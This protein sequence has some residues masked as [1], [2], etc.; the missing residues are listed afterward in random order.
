MMAEVDVSFDEDGAL[1]DGQVAEM[2]ESC[3][4]NPIIDSEEGES[5]S[6]L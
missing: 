3:S 6:N 5:Y 4:N 2:S 1:H